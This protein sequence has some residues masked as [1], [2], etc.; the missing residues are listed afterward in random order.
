MPVR[1]FPT[2]LNGKSGVNFIRDNPDIISNDPGLFRPGPGS[3]RIAKKSPSV[4]RS[5]SVA[6]FFSF[7]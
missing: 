1:L 3:F 7:W 2:I 4:L 5:L 6:L